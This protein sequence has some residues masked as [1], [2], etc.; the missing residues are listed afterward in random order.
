MLAKQRLKFKCGVEKRHQQD[1]RQ[2]PLVDQ[3]SKAETL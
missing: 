2:A 3:A 1:Q